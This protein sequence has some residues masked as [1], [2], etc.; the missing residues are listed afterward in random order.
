MERKMN[1][2]QAKKWKQ[3]ENEPKNCSTKK[4]TETKTSGK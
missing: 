2:K 1:G 3:S 4:K